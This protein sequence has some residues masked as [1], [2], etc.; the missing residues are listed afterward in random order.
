MPVTRSALASR[1]AERA[2][3]S[4]AP[5]M[6]S[7]IEAA[8]ASMRLAFARSVPSPARKTT[9]ASSGARLSSVRLRSSF[10]KNLASERRARSTRSLPATMARPPSAAS[11]LAT[12]TKRGASAPPASSS[13]KYFWFARI[14]AVITSGGRSMNAAS[15]RPISGTGHSTSPVTSLRSASSGDDLQASGRSELPGALDDRPAPLHGIQDDAR[16]PQ[17]VP[18][19][20]RSR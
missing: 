19:S 17:L 18:R 8:S 2:M 16:P 3:P 7:A 13:A 10:Q 4:S 20:R 12:T 1:D 6:C 9:L 11:V 14:V 5:G 15:I